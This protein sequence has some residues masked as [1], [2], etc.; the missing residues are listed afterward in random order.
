MNDIRQSDERS[1]IT[2]PPAWQ[3]FDH[4]TLTMHTNTSH[5]IGERAK[6]ARGVQIRAGAVYIY[7]YGGTC[8]KI[9]A[10]AVYT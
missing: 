4:D 3:R 2:L 7:M 1:V 5:I 9:V 8:S 10:Y 6:Q